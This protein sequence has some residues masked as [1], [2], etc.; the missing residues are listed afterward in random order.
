MCDFKCIP[1]G[2]LAYIAS[3]VAIAIADEVT[4]NDELNVLA[5]LVTLVGDNLSLIAA[6][7]AAC[8]PKKEDC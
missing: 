2:Q 3:T 4:D 7:R 6:Q 5:L 8:P 1:G